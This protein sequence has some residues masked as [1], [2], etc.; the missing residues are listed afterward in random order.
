MY[1]TREFDDM[2]SILDLVEESIP[3][4]EDQEERDLL[5]QAF[6][7]RAVTMRDQGMLDEA[8]RYGERALEMMP[9]QTRGS[10][11]DANGITSRGLTLTMLG[12]AYD[13][14]GR[15]RQG[16]A[17][18]EEGLRFSR[19]LGDK[20]SILAAL[21]N[22][23]RSYSTQGR[24]ED[25]MR[26]VREI[27]S[28]QESTSYG[29]PGPEAIPWQIETRVN[30]E[31][32]QIDEATVAARNAI[33]LCKPFPAGQYLEMNRMM[34]LVSVAAGDLDEAHRRLQAMQELPLSGP[35]QKLMAVIRMARA[36]LAFVEGRQQEA[37]S[38]VAYLEGESPGKTARVQTGSFLFRSFAEILYA[39]I[40]SWLGRKS[41]AIALLESRRNDLLANGVITLGMESGA[42]LSVLLAA[43]GAPEALDVLEQTLIIGAPEGFIRCFVTEGAPMAR[44]LE[45]YRLSRWKPAVVPAGYLGAVFDAC[46]LAA[47]GTARTATPASRATT[48]DDPDALTSREL[49]ILRLM[50]IG[51]SNQKIADKLY[52]SINTVKTHISN[53]FDKL[54]ARNRVDA[55]VRAREAGVLE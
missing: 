40:L 1:F 44:L 8:I 16:T 28:L 27:N 24:L 7:L 18:F 11:V 25:A 48:I 21:G 5:G 12:G 14:A 2:M 19:Q 45:K 13:L 51:Y 46:G 3:E 50:S 35:D 17:M 26:C 36:Y 4:A 20:F 47:N 34:M 41:D 43:E 10:A 42:I 31:R 52:L 33:D 6:L 55:L 32:N 30:Y 54:G 49:E 39:R 29:I 9:E 37:E 15:V 22:L 38:W 53:V 23:G